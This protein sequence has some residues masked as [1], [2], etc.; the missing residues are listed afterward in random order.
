MWRHPFAD[1]VSTLNGSVLLQQCC[2][3][4]GQEEPRNGRMP[5]CSS[6]HYRTIQGTYKNN[7]LYVGIHLLAFVLRTGE[8]IWDTHK[9]LIGF[10]ATLQKTKQIP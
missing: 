8:R 1:E 9:N 3:I 2:T 7:E 4:V 6:S 5:K 10:L